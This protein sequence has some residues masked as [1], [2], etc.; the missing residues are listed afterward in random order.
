LSKT[1]NLPPE[2]PRFPSQ[3]NQIT[4]LPELTTR[5]R[6][7][8]LLLR[9]LAQ[10]ILL[11][12]SRVKIT[13]LENFP[14][15]GPALIVFNHL[16]DADVV[17]GLAS[18]PS[19]RIQ[20]LAKIDLFIEYPLLG[21]LMETYGV[22][23]I[24]PGSPDRRA[25]RAALQALQKGQFVA[26]APEGRQSLSGEL[27]EGM[28]G[29]AYLAIKTGTGI[30]PVGVTGTEN[31]QVYGKIRHFRKAEIT[32]Q[33]GKLFH[34]RE[35]ELN[36]EAVRKGTLVIMERIAEQIPIEYRGVYK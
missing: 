10:L 21:W 24:H 25:L 26:I 3:F 35:Q 6:F 15:Q 28:G 7:L 29:A 30:L 1:T 33:I 22:I 20:T 4:R 18:L 31:T 17:V 32:L 5:R 11:I 9:A 27:E 12:T 23:W 14:A 16:G 8:R 34:L 19:G 2:K 13:G 36:R